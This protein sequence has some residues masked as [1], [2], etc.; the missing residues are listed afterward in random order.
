MIEQYIDLITS[1]NYE[2]ASFL[3]NEESRQ[4]SNRFGISFSDIPLK[5]DAGS[6]LVRFL[7]IVRYEPVPPQLSVSPLEDSVYK[8]HYSQFAG[9]EVFGHDYYATSKNGYFR[10]IYPQDY[11]GRDWQVLETKFLRVR[12]HSAM[13]H[14]LNDALLAEVDEFVLRLSNSLGL[15]QMDMDATKEQKIEFFYCDSDKTVETITGALVK[16]TLD[17]A[18]NDIISAGFPHYH[19]LVHLLV[20]IRLKTM[21]LYTLPLFREGV[22]VHF[23]GRWGKTP[24]AL[25]D[26]SAFLYRQGLVDIDS[27]LTMDGFSRD[28]SADIVYPIAG[29][30]AGFLIKRIGITPYFQLYRRLSGDLPE[31]Q[32]LSHDS[33]AVIIASGLNLDDWPSVVV[34]F[35][36]YIE[37]TQS[38]Y[39]LASPGA[40]GAT[41]ASGAT[42]ETGQGKVLLE[43]S[44]C[45]VIE[46]S[47]WVGFEFA[48]K[49]Q[50]GSGT[51]LFGVDKRFGE[52]RSRLF[53]EQFGDDHEFGGYR[54]SVRFDR[55]EA[56]LYDYVSNQLVAKHI[57]GISPPGNYMSEDSTR[58]RFRVRRE[59]LGEVRPSEDDFLFLNK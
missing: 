36:S 10:L 16:G 31:L 29:S 11:I 14:F 12:T 56:G 13:T 57:E 33:V 20:N 35:D 23:G 2:S 41:G 38:G 46:N 25:K 27:I 32:R 34:A 8:I 58:I 15:T 17:L 53:D 21:P 48:Y 4:R 7:D 37:E 59:L 26:L 55:N 40:T 5:T 24:E 43:T 3:W 52:K 9:G 18:S 50:D 39:R 45:K 51:L 49:G 47:E 30:F 42:G 22:A 28:A 6:P 54:F 1:D 44:D 19:E